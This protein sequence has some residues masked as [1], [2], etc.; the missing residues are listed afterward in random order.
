MHNLARDAALR[1]SIDSDQGVTSKVY[2][3]PAGGGTE[4]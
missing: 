1:L 3:L 2:G 4:G